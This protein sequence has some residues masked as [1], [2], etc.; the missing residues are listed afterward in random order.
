M[1]EVAQEASIQV[2]A[3]PFGYGVEDTKIPVEGVAVPAGEDATNPNLFE[4]N[5]TGPSIN[6]VPVGEQQAESVE[7]SQESSS[8]KADPSRFEYWQSQADKVKANCPQPSRS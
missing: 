7:S 3:D 8:A 6:E 5:T 2:D 4:V 1:A